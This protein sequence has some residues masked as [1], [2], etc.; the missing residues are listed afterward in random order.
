VP[1]PVSE[2]IRAAKTRVERDIGTPG[3]GKL[4]KAY[5]DPA[6]GFAG[7]MFDTLGANPRNEITRDDLL[8]VTLLDVRWSPSAVRRLL[9]DDAKQATELLAGITSVKN[10]WEVS[11][12]KLAATDPLWRLLTKGSDGVGQTRASKLLARKRPRL[13]PITDSI[14]VGRV[15]AIGETWQAL[16]YC[17]QD[18]SLRQ[19]IKALR[20]QQAGTAS[21]LRLLDVALWMLHSQSKA[22]RKARDTAGVTP[23]R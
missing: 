15:G 9:G 11:E 17:L 1:A 6:C 7:A 13:V 8:A 16:R 18:A 5:F 22:A 20:P 3:L 2:A 4:L 12:E 10:L 14:I 19:A 23:E 21:V